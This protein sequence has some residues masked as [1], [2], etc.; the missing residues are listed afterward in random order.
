MNKKTKTGQK[1]HDESVLRSAEWCKKHGFTTNA[2]LPGWN[3]P[4]KIEE[5]KSKKEVNVS[6]VLSGGMLF[7]YAEVYLNAV[8]RLVS[9]E[10]REYRKGVYFK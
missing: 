5:I 6:M 2:G 1:K 4:K 10:N 3:K 7:S 9:M 8:N